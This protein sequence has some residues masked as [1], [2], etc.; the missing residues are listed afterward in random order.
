MAANILW[1]DCIN[2]VA[3]SFSK[4]QTFL[5]SSD[6]S[7]VTSAEARPAFYPTLILAHAYIASASVC[8]LSIRH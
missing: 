6:C 8:C 3:Q 7:V 4:V 1:C 2:V 5:Y